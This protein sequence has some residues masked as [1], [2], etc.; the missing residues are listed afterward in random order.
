MEITMTYG[1]IV[2]KAGESWN[3]YVPEL[4]GVY[5]VASSRERVIELIARAI[6]YHLRQLAEAGV[7]VAVDHGA[8]KAL[9]LAIA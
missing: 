1:V 3:A 5:A 8:S 6:P 2:H 4:E 9:T 7:T